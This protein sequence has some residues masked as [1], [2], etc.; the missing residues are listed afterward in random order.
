[1]LQSVLQNKSN[2][3]NSA[4][5]S[6]F[7][8][9]WAQMT[10]GLVI[11]DAGGKVRICN[12]VFAR[13]LRRSIEDIVGMPI[14]GLMVRS[15]AEEFTKRS[16]RA[17][18]QNDCGY[19]L[20][21]RPTGHERLSLPARSWPL[22]DNSGRLDGCALMTMGAEL[23]R[24]GKEE[25]AASQ[26]MLTP[27]PVVLYRVRVEEGL[28]VEFVSGNMAHFGYVTEELASGAAHFEKVV[29]SEDRQ[30]VLNELNA[31]LARGDREF[32][33]HYRVGTTGGAILWAEDHTYVRDYAGGAGLYLE[34]V[35]T[36]VT[37]RH[38]AH[39][40]LRT[41]LT[42]TIGAIAATIDKR[43]PYTAGHQ[44]RTADLARAI[45]VD[46]GL[47]PDR[48]EGVYL[49][50]LVHDVGKIAIPVDIL[51]RP[52]RLSPEEFALV[53]THVQAGV[54]VLRDVAFPWPIVDM[55]GQ[56]H[57]RLDG[58]GY[59]AGLAGEA[60]LLESR[61]VAVADVFESM[62]TNR[63]YRTALG[64]EVVCAELMNGRGRTYDAD[65]VD[66]CLAI[67]RAHENDPPGIWKA[68]APAR[69]RAATTP[70]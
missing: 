2:A 64:L 25:L 58:S 4:D 3:M 37:E 10:D 16:L 24:S 12:A 63:P 6:G 19:F 21:W 1:M 52:G 36:D 53:K 17:C 29:H 55:V 70:A 30:R 26:F 13:L 66:A 31:H 22:F 57:E 68:L 35:I 38:L 40:R 39:H 54:D 45:A 15:S 28:P 14:E 8:P 43:D 59:P 9:D 48:A 69:V 18:D 60:I 67:V 7:S 20:T 27:A 51:T 47:G 41:V 49:G 11:V 34:G 61:I 56:H 32:V 33:L 23:E 42:Q 62:S 46:L 44:R 5:L 50:A 65:V